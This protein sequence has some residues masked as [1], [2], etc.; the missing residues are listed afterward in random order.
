MIDRRFQAL[1]VRLIS[2]FM[3]LFIP[4]VF[5]GQPIIDTISITINVVAALWYLGEFA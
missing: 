1:T 5:L 2:C 3:W 4:L